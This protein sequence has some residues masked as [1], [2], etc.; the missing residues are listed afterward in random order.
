MQRL[1]WLPL[2]AAL[3]ACDGVALPFSDDEGPATVEARDTGDDDAPDADEAVDVVDTAPIPDIS[4]GDVPEPDVPDVVDAASD[5]ADADADAMRVPD[6]PPDVVA[7]GP[8]RD[9]DRVADDDD[10]APDDPTV[11]GDSD[12]DGCDDCTIW[13]RIA[14]LDDGF[15]ADHDGLCEVAL[16]AAC[17]HGEYAADDPHRR[18][19][20]LLHALT[21]LERARLVDES[22]AAL[23]ILWDERVWVI[24]Q[25]HNLDMCA[26]D[27]YGSV[28]PDGV[29]PGERLAALD[30]VINGQAENL[31]GYDHVLQQHH[32]WMA[33][34][35]CTGHRG[36]L[37]RP[38]MSRGAVS[39][40][41]CDNPDAARFE[42][43][44]TVQDLVVDLTLRERPWDPPA[45]CEDPAT[46]CEIPPEPWSIA[47]ELC[48]MFGVD[49]DDEPEWTRWGCPED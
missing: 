3:G 21:N 34:P 8:D 41:R 45:Y 19:A 6:A 25:A 26:R 46:A 38:L 48:V 20:C 11:C 28:D 49:C 32:Y 27:Y 1:W 22:G 47:A 33:Q 18:E 37:L 39:V 10:P 31:N 24:A 12:G 17:M 43:L 5:A 7:D 14:P 36:A 2:V 23:P 40:T 35:T 42:R 30:F 9:D 16:D 15:D 44:T 13:A 4:M 29:G